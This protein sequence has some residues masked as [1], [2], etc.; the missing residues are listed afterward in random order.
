MVNL[1]WYRTFKAIYETGTLTQASKIL[2]ISQPNV[3][4]HLSF[5]E[6]HIG[7]KL[8]E[9]KPR[10]MVPTD[11]GK[12][13]YAQLI[14]PLE[15]LQK[16][17]AEFRYTK[18]SDIP[19]T[20]IGVSSNF[21]KIKLA[22][23]VAS[24]SV[25]LVFEFDDLPVLVDNLVQGNL[26]FLI[27]E[28]HGQERNIYYEE[29]STIEE[30]LV[31]SA[32]LDTTLLESPKATETE[33]EEWLLQQSW[34]AFSSDLVLIK[35]FWQEN[36]RK[37]PNIKPKLIIPD[38]SALIQTL[39]HGS[40][41]SIVPNYIAKEYLAKKSIKEICKKFKK[42]TRKLYLAYH[43]NVVTSKQIEMIKQIVSPQL[44]E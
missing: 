21:Y 43:K 16:L 8:F 33:I 17:E 13:F 42:S 30:I 24:S 14:S 44:I 12:L 35:G 32:N 26:N 41:V 23:Q 29:I 22:S 34:Y 28:H 5:L 18:E 31:T 7:K 36:F 6:A 10:R 20:C 1:E 11:Y 38:F 4:Q 25:N 3:S 40:A 27:S 19:L 15:N 39:E 37:R 2:L 9:R